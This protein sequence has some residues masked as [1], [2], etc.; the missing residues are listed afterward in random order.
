MSAI[1]SAIMMV[2]MFVFAH[3][4]DGISEASQTCKPCTP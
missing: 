2:G 3:G 4:M 1:R